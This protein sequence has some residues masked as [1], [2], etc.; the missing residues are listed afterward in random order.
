MCVSEKTPIMN[1]E[2]RMMS[3]GVSFLANDWGPNSE[4]LIKQPFY[5]PG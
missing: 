2:C 3:C 4:V 5:S 1:K